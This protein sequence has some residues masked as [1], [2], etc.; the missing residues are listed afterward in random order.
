MAI[1]IEIRPLEV[2]YD[3]EPS[4][5][6]A[7]DECAEL[8]RKNSKNGFGAD[9]S[10]GEYSTGWTWKVEQDSSGLYVTVFNDTQPSLTHLLEFGHIVAN[11]TGTHG[12]WYPPKKHIEPAYKRVKKKYYQSLKNTKFKLVSK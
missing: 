11:Q 12:R 1:E 2:K 4:L 3:L 9:Y 10:T 6:Q 5:V 7:G 8:I